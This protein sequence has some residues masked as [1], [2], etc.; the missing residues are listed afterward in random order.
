ML[1][2]AI[3]AASTVAHAQTYSVL[4]NFQTSGGGPYQPIG[5]VA[6]GHDGNMYSTA[7]VG[8]SIGYGAMFKITPSGTLTVPYSFDSTDQTPYGGLTLGT[9]GNFYGTTFGDNEFNLGTVFKLTPSGTFT[10]LHTFAGSDGSQPYAPPI[11]G[12]DG[13]FY[14]TTAKGGANNAGTVYKITPSGAL[15]TLYSFGGVLGADPRAPLVQGTDGDF[16]GTTVAGGTNAFGTVYKITPAGHLTTLWSFDGNDGD[17]PYAPLVQGTDGNF[18]GTTELGGTSN[19]S[20]TVYKITP[21]G[22][23][24]VLHNIGG[25]DGQEPV[26]GLVQA[27]DGNFYGVAGGGG[28]KDE[29]T[30][31][32]ISPKSPYAYT[33]L[34]NFDG[35]TGAGPEVG[36]LQHTNGI[37]YSDTILGGT[38]SRGVFYSLN[39]GLKPFVSLVSTS[40]K[41]GKTIEILGQGFIGTTGVSFNGTP[42]TVFTVRSKTFLTAKVPSGAT[43]GVVTVTTPKRKLTSNKKFRV[44]P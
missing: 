5:I 37:L 30:I 40:G 16:Y 36:L 41:V 18:Y 17:A 7:P 3:V 21:A 20:G 25:S 42:A 43:T 19:D 11:Q 38:G 29:G 10:P 32:R 15:T 12:T 26:A 4:Y 8:G 33:V 27:T 35:T 39:V 31:F 14:G 13:N 23:L 1:M 6:Q 9:D 44:I 22:N 2:L 24:T 28:T 34:Y